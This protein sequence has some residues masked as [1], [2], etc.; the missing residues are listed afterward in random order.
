MAKE[1]QIVLHESED[2]KLIFDKNKAWFYYINDEGS[3]G[4]VEMI[5]PGYYDLT[6]EE[7]GALQKWLKGNLKDGVL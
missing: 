4:T 1:R 7:V 5:R 6:P 3:V 2:G